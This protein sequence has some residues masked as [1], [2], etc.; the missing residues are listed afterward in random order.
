MDLGLYYGW[1]FE[2][3][4]P[5]F[6]TGRTG[7]D[8]PSYVVDDYL[9]NNQISTMQ[10]TPPPDLSSQWD[11]RKLLKMFLS[12]CLFWSS[13][14][15]QR[16]RDGYLQLNQISNVQS[17]SLP[18]WIN[19]WDRSKLLIMF[20]APCLFWGYNDS[21]HRRGSITHRLREDYHIFG[22][23]VPLL[24]NKEGYCV[25]FRIGSR[26]YFMDF[27][28]NGV[29][30]VVARIFLQPEQIMS[31]G[32]PDNILQTNLACEMTPVCDNGL[33][34]LR[35]HEDTVGK[36]LRFS[37]K[38]G[39]TSEDDSQID[40]SQ[41]KWTYLESMYD[42]YVKCTRD[43]SEGYGDDFVDWLKQRKIEK[44]SDAEEL[45]P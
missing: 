43:Y 33:R 9:Q 19:Q 22:H 29:V 28:G 35:N 41:E 32:V 24:Y 17:T 45:L 23:P 1:H 39:L 7:F 38:A 36:V 30:M 13:N 10:W 18:Y 34:L 2:T 31:G 6:W 42:D 3:P 8:V 25:I 37:A 14:D 16:R 27:V 4:L 20:L 12:P 40:W 21:V 5:S 11:C 26:S 44:Y 15:S